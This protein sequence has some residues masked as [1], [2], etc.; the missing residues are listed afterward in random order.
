MPTTWLQCKEPKTKF[1]QKIK[2]PLYIAKDGSKEFINELTNYVLELEN[3]II[4]REGLVSPVP[5]GSEDPYKHTQQWKQHNILKD[6]VG[7]DGE[8]LERFPPNP[9]TEK[10]F[11]MVREHYLRHLANLG[12]PRIKA[13]IHGWA[14]VLSPGEW[15]SR[16][17]HI[18]GEESYLACTYYL[19]TNNTKLYLVGHESQEGTALIPTEAGK[20]V[21]FPSWMMHWS[22]A[23]EEDKHRISLAFD[24]VTEDTM[25]A[26]PWRP[27]MLLDDPAT[28]PGLEG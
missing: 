25:R 23:C 13:Y 2:V 28:M 9:V 5:K 16:H 10:L 19:T 4:S 26:N 7:L 27:H 21:F 22:D 18:V 3:G 24:I 6:E 1:G 15:I 12:Y 17:C 20:I 14:N 11:S 8:H